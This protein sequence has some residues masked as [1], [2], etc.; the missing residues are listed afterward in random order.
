MPTPLDKAISSN[1]RT[2][3]LA[4]AGV[5][6]AASAWAI[7]GSDMFPADTDPKGNP[8]GWEDSD[9]RRWLQSRGLLPAQKATR[10]ELIERVK[11]N[12]RPASKP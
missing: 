7:W 4:F 1:S 6:T 2:A 9:L 11:A 10:E 8:E 12:M 5:V 3:F